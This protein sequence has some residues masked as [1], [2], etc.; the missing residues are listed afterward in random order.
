MSVTIRDVARRAQVSISTVSRVLND[1][2]RVSEEKRRRVLEAAEQL[3]YRPN[4]V[5]RSLLTKE[6]GALGV[7]V[8]FVFGEFFAE[9]LNGIDAAAQERAFCLTISTSH[10]HEHELR[11]ALQSLHKRV[12][13]VLLMTPEMPGEQAVAHLPEDV[14]VVFLN[15]RLSGDG[16]AVVNFD[17]AGGFRALTRH[18]IALGH[19]RIAVITGPEAAFDAAERLRGYRM[20]LEEAG[21]AFD[22]A[23]LIPG[24]YSQR[25]GY[26]AVQTLLAWPERPTAILAS[27]DQMAFG[28]LSAL[29][30]AGLRVPEDVSL[31]GFDDVPS[32][33]YTVPS[34]TSA[35]VPIRDLGARAVQCL[36]DHIQAETPPAPRSL[37]L[38]VD[39]VVRD[40]TAPV[41]GRL[42]TAA[43]EPTARKA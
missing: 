31:A 6:T 11:A 14:P 4:P 3:G 27:N 17:N 20:A 40:S 25:A 36:V 38:P 39:L 33:R 22:P 35:R 43:I 21:M 8:P 28:A 12:D 41:G 15:T 19:R 7:V 42:H 30:E 37:V 29:R 34:L 26:E 9:L 24:D 2:C 32:A 10:R 16:Y 23:W 18:L 1:T 13:G 5:A